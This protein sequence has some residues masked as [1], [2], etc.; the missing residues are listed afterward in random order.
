[1]RIKWERSVKDTHNRHRSCCLRVLLVNGC[2]DPNDA[3]QVSPTCLA[4]IDERF[5]NTK[6]RDIRAFHKGLF[7][8]TIDDSLDRLE[9]EPALR[10][11]I[12]SQI[13]EKIS[14][15]GD[16]WPLWAVTCIPRYDP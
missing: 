10:V 14:R 8:K 15:P 12:E 7:W 3:K 1:M 6:A 5:L 4:S 9:M 13:A 11:R 16:D 2:L